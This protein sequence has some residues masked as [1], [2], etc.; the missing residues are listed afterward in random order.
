MLVLLNHTEAENSD[1]IQN[2]TGSGNGR[3]KSN[4]ISNSRIFSQD[5]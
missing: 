5:F 1:F 3:D 4:K 2:N